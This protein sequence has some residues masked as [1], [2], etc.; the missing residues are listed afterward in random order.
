MTPTTL[1]W[2]DFFPLI[3]LTLLL[4]ILRASIYGYVLFVRFAR[5]GIK[6]FSIYIEKSQT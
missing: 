3:N 4:M 2:I 5:L 1:S 6:A